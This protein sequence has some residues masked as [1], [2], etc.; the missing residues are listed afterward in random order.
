MAAPLPRSMIAPP[1]II[2]MAMLSSAD[3]VCVA[4]RAQIEPSA[5]QRWRHEQHARAG[6]RDDALAVLIFAQYDERDPG[7]SYGE[8]GKGRPMRTNA[9]W[10]Q[11]FEEIH[12]QRDGG[13]HERR[14]IRRHG[15]F[16][17]TDAAVSREEQE[18]AG[19]DRGA[20]PV[21]G[22]AGS[23]RAGRAQDRIEKRAGEQQPV[24]RP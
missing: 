20:L 15:L 7:E 21:H 17:P 9:C 14:D 24:R 1:Q 8:S 19:H 12:P 22:A 10:P 4:C 3:D 23:R 2:C 16:R 11:P 5:Q 18:T 6:Q 13:D